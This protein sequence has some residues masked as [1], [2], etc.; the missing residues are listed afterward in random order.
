MNSSHEKWQIRPMQDTDLEEVARL[1]EQI[2]TLPWTRKGFEDALHSPYAYYLCAVS[3][4]SI[5]GYAG[6]LR[7]FEEA[8]IT[9]MAV[10]PAH[11]R[12]HIGEKLLS[13]LMRAGM[14]NGIERFTLEVR[15]GNTGARRL[16]EK[17]GY[18]E[19]GRRKGFYDY[20]K[21]D[22]LIL[23]GRVVLVELLPSMVAW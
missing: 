4:G 9:N 19:E 15:V 18:R 21:E 13:S 10:S 20:P 12:R 8:T 23:P 16:Y 3:G 17:L 6:Y 5:I 7:S 2:F 11:R 22:A 1:E 14:E